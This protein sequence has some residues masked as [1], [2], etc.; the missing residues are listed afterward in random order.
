MTE[1]LAIGTFV[2]DEWFKMIQRM[3]M[4]FDKKMVNNYENHESKKF[5]VRKTNLVFVFLFFFLI[6]YYRNIYL[7]FINEIK[8]IKL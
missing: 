4:K 3:F 8:S 6:F 7:T 1:L 2:K 5:F